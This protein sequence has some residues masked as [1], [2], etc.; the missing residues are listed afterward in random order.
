MVA[1]CMRELIRIPCQ[2]MLTILYPVKL[3]YME[4]CQTC[5]HLCAYTIVLYTLHTYTS[6][7]C[8]YILLM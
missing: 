3:D 6:C 8:I 1:K 2:H 4:T 7:M 5:I